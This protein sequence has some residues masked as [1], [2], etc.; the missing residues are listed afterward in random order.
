MV[1]LCLQHDFVCQVEFLLLKKRWS[2]GIDFALTLNFGQVDDIHKEAPAQ[3]ARICSLDRLQF[4]V[5]LHGNPVLP[6]S[7][8]LCCDVP[9]EWTE[10]PTIKRVARIKKRCILEKKQEIGIP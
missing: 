8:Q 4:P 6:E 5:P 1:R 3:Q 10:V 2:D 7:G 9:P